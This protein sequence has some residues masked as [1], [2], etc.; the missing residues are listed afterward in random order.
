MSFNFAK[1]YSTAPESLQKAQKLLEDATEEF[2]K[3]ADLESELTRKYAEK[4]SHSVKQ[5]I[6]E[7]FGATIATKIAEG[8]AATEK[9]ELMAASGHKKKAQLMHENFKERIFN[10]RHLCKEIDANIKN[11]Q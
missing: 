2:G 3:Y 9:A 4:L 6:E 8:Y 1:F 10:I 7:G 11:G 5:A